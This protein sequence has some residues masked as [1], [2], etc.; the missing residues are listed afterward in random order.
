MCRFSSIRSAI[1]R[2]AGADVELTATPITAEAYRPYGDVLSADRD[3]IA[4]SAANQGTAAKRS[5]Q[6]DV[7]HLSPEARPN[8]SSFRCA[9]RAQWPM[10]L[11]LLEKHPRSTQTFV[12]MNGS[13]YLVV[14][15]LGGDTPDLSTLRAFVVGPGMAVSYRPG[16]WHH[17]MIALGQVTDFACLVWEAGAADDTVEHEMGP[18]AIVLQEPRAGSATPPK[19]P[20]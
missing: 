19:K 16:T 1:R 9:P 7:I 14:V 13:G 8:F 15:S 11:L 20:G 12:P 4:A 5:H 17:P 18:Q 10:P 6:I 3:D 2:T